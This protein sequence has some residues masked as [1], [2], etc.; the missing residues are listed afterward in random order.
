MKQCP[1]CQE[2]YSGYSDHILDKHPIGC[3]NVVCRFEDYSRGRLDTETD[4]KVIIHISSCQGCSDELSK[5]INRQ[6]QEYLEKREA[7]IDRGKAL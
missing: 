3:E 5:F 6:I 7:G 2:Q 4:E 1:F